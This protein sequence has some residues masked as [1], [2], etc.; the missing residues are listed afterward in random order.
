MATTACSATVTRT[1][2]T[3]TGAA[4]GVI[5]QYEEDIEHLSQLFTAKNVVTFDIGHM[6]CSAGSSSGDNYMS[7]VKRVTIYE[8]AGGDGEMGKEVTASITIKEN[9]TQ[10]V[11]LA[12]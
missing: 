5:N 2:T 4:N 10:A 7:L 12:Y 11:F 6:A 8:A 9:S 1:T 3:S